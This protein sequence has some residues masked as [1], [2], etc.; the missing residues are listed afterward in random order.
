MDEFSEK[1]KK[2]N[3]PK[4]TQDEIDNPNNH[5]SVK[6]INLLL[7][8]FPQ[9]TLK[10]DGLTGKFCQIFKGKT[11]FTQTLSENRGRGVNTS[12]LIL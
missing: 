7:K 10:L 8:I 12:Q 4:L 9:R 11:I 3:L 2:Y 1:E 6:E 5:I